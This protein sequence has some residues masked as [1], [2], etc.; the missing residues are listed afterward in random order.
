M[1]ETARYIQLYKSSICPRCRQAEQYLRH[2]L[3]NYPQ[4]TLYSFD[5]LRHP[6]L[7]IRKKVTMIPTLISD[8]D[9]RLSGFMLNEHQIKTFL[10]D[11]F[12]ML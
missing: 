2:E 8:T 5:I 9:V 11:N 3:T 4:V 1:T 7:Y 10:E 12:A 6:L